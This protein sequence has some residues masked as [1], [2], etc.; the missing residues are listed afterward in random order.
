M[1]AGMPM[2]R[3][4]W[5]KTPSF[6][7]K[8]GAVIIGKDILRTFYMNYFSERG[9]FSSDDILAEDWIPFDQP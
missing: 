8:T 2:R 9:V 6:R 5:D 1:K 3:K 4:V 7:R